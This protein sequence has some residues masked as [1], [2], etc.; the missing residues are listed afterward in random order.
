MWDDTAHRASSGEAV[1]RRLMNSIVRFSVY[2]VLTPLM[3]IC[4]G[5]LYV[6]LFLYSVVADAFDENKR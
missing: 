5:V 1:I 3:L 4:F 6:F 2:I